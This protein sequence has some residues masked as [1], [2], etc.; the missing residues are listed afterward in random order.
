[1]RQVFHGN[2]FLPSEYAI[3]FVVQLL[4][5]STLFKREGALSVLCATVLDKYQSPQHESLAYIMSRYS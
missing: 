1:M 4:T 3:S 5:L 2:W